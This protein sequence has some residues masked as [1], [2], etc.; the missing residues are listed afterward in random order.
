S[1]IETKEVR[2]QK[3]KFPWLP[4]PFPF[5]SESKPAQEETPI[6]RL[7]G[8]LRD[9]YNA[10]VPNR[11]IKIEV[12]S[13]NFTR[14]YNVTTDSSGNFKIDVD[15]AEGVE[16]KVTYKFAGDDVYV[17]TS[18]TKTFTIE[19]LLPAPPE[20]MTITELLIFVGIAIGLVAVVAGAIYLAKRTKAKT[21][22]R[23]ES[24][25]KFFRRLK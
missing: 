21:L 3:T 8:T 14:I 17:G 18:T 13:P 4:F 24:E 25:F 22:A 1:K 11:T 9:F 10:P 23:M 15:M 7:E 5:L 6:V 2:I 12:A 16:Y 19:Q 20:E